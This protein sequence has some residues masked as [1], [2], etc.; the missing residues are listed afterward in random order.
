MSTMKFTMT[1]PAAT[2]STTPCRM[3]KSRAQIADRILVER[4]PSG[5]RQPVELHGKQVDQQDRH[6]EGGQREAAEGKAGEEAIDRAAALHGAEDR[7]R[8]ADRQPHQLGHDHEL[9]RYR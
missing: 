8:N 7:E 6:H 2:N 3:M 1:K 9:E 4:Y 5:R